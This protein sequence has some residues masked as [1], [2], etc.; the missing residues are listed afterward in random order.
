MWCSDQD[1]DT[2]WCLPCVVSLLASY[3]REA[4]W[5]LLFHSPRQCICRHSKVQRC[6]KLFCAWL[7]PSPDR[8]LLCLSFRG[9][10]ALAEPISPMRLSQQQAAQAWQQ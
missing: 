4:L 5:L 10:T 9:T 2:I 6:I 7:G 1:T 8:V 3:A